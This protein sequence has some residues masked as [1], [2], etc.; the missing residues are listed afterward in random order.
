MKDFVGILNILVRREIFETAGYFD[1][2]LTTYEDI[3]WILRVAFHY[4]FS[5]TPGPVAIYR[6][7]HQG[8]YVTDVRQGRTEREFRPIMEKALAMLPNSAKSTQ[9]LRQQVRARVELKIAEELEWAR[10][11][12]WL[13]RAPT[14]HAETKSQNNRGV[15]KEIF[16]DPLSAS[17]MWAHIIA[18]LKECPAISE[19]PAARLLMRRHVFRLCLASKDPLVTMRSLCMQIRTATKGSSFADRWKIRKLLADLWWEAASTFTRRHLYKLTGQAGL[20][21]VLNN[22]AKLAQGGLWITKSAVLT[23]R[24][25]LI[26]LFSLR[27]LPLSDL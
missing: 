7:S 17:L 21:A 15:E 20:R 4:R 6:L 24:R 11:P 12:E 5:F 10:E 23:P 26:L 18:S 19:D 14:P 27:S 3:D 2:G 25:H 16:W 9:H 1:E 13:E 22:P 8:K